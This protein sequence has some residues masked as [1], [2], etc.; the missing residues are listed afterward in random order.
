MKKSTRQKSVLLLLTFGSSVSLPATVFT[1]IGDTNDTN[2]LSAS[3]GSTWVGQPTLSVGHNSTHGLMSVFHMFALP[4]IPAGEVVT[5]ASLSFQLTKVQSFGAD[6]A[7]GD[8]FALDFRSTPSVTIADHYEGSF[9]GST[10]TGIQDDIITRLSS[11][12]TIT[13][14]ATGSANLVSYVNTQISNGATSGDFLIFRYNIDDS[15]ATSSRYYSIAMADHSTEAFRPVLSL[16]TQPSV[17]AVPEPSV[18]G[19]AT[20]LAGLA[21]LSTRRKLRTEK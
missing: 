18:L 5:S 1:I 6:L 19:F 17:I 9:S 10:D 14:D 20:G 3:G 13:T 7:N 15:I 12:G 4:A 2:I 21:L 8:L 16:T 11:L